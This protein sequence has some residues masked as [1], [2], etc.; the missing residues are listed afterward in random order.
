[1]GSVSQSSIIITR[2]FV[3]QTRSRDFSDLLLSKTQKEETPEQ[4][5][6]R[7]MDFRNQERFMNLA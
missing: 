2:L 4:C 5:F 7:I 1:M 3:T 6:L